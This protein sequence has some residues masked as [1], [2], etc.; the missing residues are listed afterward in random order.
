MKRRF[1]DTE[2]AKIGL[3]CRFD[4]PPYHEKAFFRHGGE[5]FY[6]NLCIASPLRSFGSNQVVF[7][8]IMLPESAIST[9]CF[10]ETG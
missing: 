3:K 5:R 9:S 4:V 10:I 1:S 7:G 8:G 2:V 6:A